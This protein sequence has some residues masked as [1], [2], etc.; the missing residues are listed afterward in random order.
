MTGFAAAS[1]TGRE[2]PPISARTA[3]ILALAGA[4]GV[5]G[6]VV[7][8]WLPPRLDVAALLAVTVAAVMLGAWWQEAEWPAGAP[9]LVAGG[10]AGVGALVWRDSPALFMLN[11]IGIAGC[12]L[13]GS[14]AAD[15]ARLRLAGVTAWVREAL[16]A[17]L[18]T[19]MGALPAMATEVRWGDLPL[20]GRMRRAGAAGVGLLAAL[21]VLVVFGGLFASA[22]PLFAKAVDRIFVLDVERFAGHA[23]RIA[24][25]AWLA[26]GMLR[27]L[28][29]APGR[30]PVETGG[31]GRV[32][33]VQVATAL[34][35]VAAL[36]AAF[37]AVQVPYLFGGAEHVARLAGLTYAEY[38]RR[39][40]FELVCVAALTLPLLLV[41]DWAL[42]KQDPRAV[43]RVRGIAWLML[44]LLSVILAS[45]LSRMALYTGA[46][47][48][49]EQRLYTTAFMG[50]LIV[51]FG[52]FGATVL[53]GARERFA[54]GALVAAGCFIVALDVANPDALIAR[55]NLARADR[56]AVF[57]AGYVTH[58]SADA[59][60]LVVAR[61][62]AL[63]AGER[64]RMTDEMAEL[65][66]TEPAAGAPW[67]VSR[68]QARSAVRAALPALVRSC[69]E[70]GGG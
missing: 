55:V 28:V 60:P 54:S 29:V 51:V 48:L 8:T 24:V 63:P 62:L 4:L 5:V 9:I 53:R 40:F 32:G 20:S 19:A 25:I 66:G 45:A 18:E 61:A 6:D 39:G 69:R 41:A 38:A 52:W 12:L 21:P 36:F 26:A 43:R 1:D 22:D 50:W 31:S 37:V 70:L 49:T 59:V 64:C 35:A 15:A 16:R 2:A 14:P 46:Y 47:G 57:D 58:L 23:A 42:D 10:V 56:G 7:A 44:G 3:R 17:G 34:G 27:T 67:T 33:M 68:M 11:V 13:A 65:W 30:V